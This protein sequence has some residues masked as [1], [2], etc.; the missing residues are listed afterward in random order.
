VQAVLAAMT[1]SPWWRRWSGWAFLAVALLSTA[2]AVVNAVRGRGFT[3][4]AALAV[5]WTAFAVFVFVR[6]QRRRP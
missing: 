4:Q 6:P 2:F 3:D 5:T 1:T